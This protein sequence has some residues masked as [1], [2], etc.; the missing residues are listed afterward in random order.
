MSSNKTTTVMRHFLKWQ[1]IIEKL[2]TK[3]LLPIVNDLDLLEELRDKKFWG[4]A[5]LTYVCAL[6]G[7]NLIIVSLGSILEYLNCL[8]GEPIVLLHS[9]LHWDR[10]IGPGVTIIVFL[11]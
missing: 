6:L 8:G 4:T 5:V 7:K 2:R 10:Y 1:V 3:Y 11:T 9:G